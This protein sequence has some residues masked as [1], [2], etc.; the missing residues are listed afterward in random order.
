MNHPEYEAVIGLEV[1]AEL[2]TASKIFCS[3]K[4]EFGAAPNTQC[5]PICM[6]LPGS[7]P[8]LNRYAV[9]LAIRA[10]LALECEIAP[11]SKFDRKQYFYPD[12]PKAYQISQ[13]K[14]P[15]CRNGRLQIRTAKGVRQIRI[16]RIHMEEDAGKLIHS[17]DGTRIDYNRSGVGL[18]E[19]VSAPDLRSGEEASA[20]LRAL[21]GIL[22]TAGVSD[23]RMQEGS[24]RCDINLSL[25]RRG[26]EALGARTE[27]KNVNSFAFAEKAIQCEILRQSELLARGERVESET[28]R[29]DEA[30]GCTVRMRKKESAADYRFL[31]EPNL[32][33]LCISQEDL[34][35]IRAAMPELPE[36]RRARLCKDYGIAEA[37][38]VILTSE[39]ALADYFEASAE[40][41]TDAVKL[42]HF[43]LGELLRYCRSDPFRSPVSAL[44]L[45]ELVALWCEE[46]INGTTA[47]R[48]LARLVEADFSPEAVAA[49]E[50]LMQIR[51]RES[52]CAM[53]RAVLADSPKAV[54]DY[55]K[56]KLAALRALQGRLMAVSGG[57]AD[58]MLGERILLEML[59]EEDDEK[60]RACE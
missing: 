27:I 48:L 24:M 12:L 44:R 47:K 52:L 4:T 39:P 31:A 13:N 57:R 32:P 45:A 6:G 20:Y 28:R 7:L 33:V 30:L 53:I 5:C 34:L 54:E 50:N 21:R 60:E 43:L 3:C 59:S 40:H 18:I 42:S 15:L 51:D 58:P 36:E 10:G 38:A 46:R 17:P 11:R 23:C 37:D 9:E 19:I 2:R 8:R 29:F 16:T 49:Q 35:P 25:R 1:H 55:R 26:E 41:C 14:Y 56:G 22:V